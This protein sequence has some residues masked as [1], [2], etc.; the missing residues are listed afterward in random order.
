VQIL[1]LRLHARRNLPAA[2]AETTDDKNAAD[3]DS[4]PVSDVVD[5]LDGLDDS[6]KDTFQVTFS[7]CHFHTAGAL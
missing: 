4:P 5:P 7:A 6:T 3:N 2:A 1:L